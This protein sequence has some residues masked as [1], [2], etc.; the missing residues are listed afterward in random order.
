MLNKCLIFAHI[1]ELSGE[2][3]NPEAE[4][5]PEAPW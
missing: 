4:K 2:Q 5:N 1:A 3:L